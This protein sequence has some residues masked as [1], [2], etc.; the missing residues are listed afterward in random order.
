MST[1]NSVFIA[2]S[3]DGFIADAEGNIDWLHKIPVPEGEDLGY[4]QFMDGIEAIVMGRVTFETVLSFGI[5]WPYEKPV[6]VLSTQRKDIPRELEGQ[7]KILHGPLKTVLRQIH[8]EGHQKL[9]I[10][11]G[12]TI[13]NFLAEDLIDELIITTIPILLGAGTALFGPLKNPLDFHGVESKV[14]QQAIIQNRYLRKR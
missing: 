1:K 10:D 9:Y 12:T 8:S 7:V 5:K 13:Q 11:G 14:Y 6:Y 4:A 2:C 3:M